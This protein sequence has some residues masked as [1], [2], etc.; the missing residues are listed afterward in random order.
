MVNNINIW[1]TCRFGDLFQSPVLNG[2]Y[3][4]DDDGSIT[5]KIV[6]MGEIFD[7]DFIGPQ[8]MDHYVVSQ[9]TFEKYRLKKDDLLFARHSLADDP[10]KSSIMVYFDTPS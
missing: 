5:V 3:S 4:R 6:K 2:Y 10:G 9:K 1:T 7:Y 8:N